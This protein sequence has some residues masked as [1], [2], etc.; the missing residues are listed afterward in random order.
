[1]AGG[2]GVEQ[3]DLV[4]LVVDSVGAVVATEVIW[5]PYRLVD[6]GGEVVP[7][8]SSFLHEVQASGR[9]AATQRSYALDL[10]RWF[11]FLWAV[12]VAWVQATRGEARD[13]CR[14]LAL[15]SLAEH[16][17]PGGPRG[18]RTR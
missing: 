2:E 1:V 3:R 11:R 8:V 12:D 10:L 17:R 18:P 15:T 14:W 5:E 9:T 16:W 6:P 7:A 4:A 13:F